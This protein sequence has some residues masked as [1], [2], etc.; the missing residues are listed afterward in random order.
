KL[1]AGPAPRTTAEAAP[2]AGGALSPREIQTMQRSPFTASLVVTLASLV[3]PAVAG[4]QATAWDDGFSAA[5]LAFLE[6]IELVPLPDG[7]AVTVSL[8]WVS[9]PRVGDAEI[10][11]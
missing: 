11:V 4:P 6:P 1:V 2:R 10:V 3:G 5:P 8:G 7:G 9:A